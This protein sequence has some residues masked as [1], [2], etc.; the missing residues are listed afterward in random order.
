MI[1][2]GTQ[3]GREHVGHA[4]VSLMLLFSRCFRRCYRAVFPLLICCF[5]HPPMGKLSSI[6]NELARRLPRQIPPEQRNRE[7]E[8]PPATGP[9]TALPADKTSRVSLHPREI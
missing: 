6:Y 1:G 2:L 7:H 3:L 8:R 5:S 4:D 9:A